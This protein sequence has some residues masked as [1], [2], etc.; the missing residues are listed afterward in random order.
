VRRGDVREVTALGLPCH[1]RSLT[2]YRNCAKTAF[3]GSKSLCKVR[4]AGW[5]S[6]PVGEDALPQ[7]NPS[8]V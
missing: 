2:N 8:V 5:E 1:G 3:L 6:G 7:V 4:S